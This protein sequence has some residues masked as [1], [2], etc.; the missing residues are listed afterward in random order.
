MFVGED[1]FK[2]D[3]LGALGERLL[4]KS[5]VTHSYPHCWR[6]K[7]KVLSRAT[8]QCFVNLLP[9]EDVALA[10]MDD[11]SWLPTWG[12]PRLA[13]AMSGRADWC[14]SRQRVWGVPVPVFYDGG[15]AVLSAEY[16]EL[17]ASVFESHGADSWFELADQD[18]NALCG[19]P[20]HLTR[21]MDTLDVWLDSGVSWLAV[22]GGAQA[23][24]YL[25][26]SDQHR[27]WFQSSLWVASALGLP[28]PYKTCV[29]H[30]WVVKDDKKFSKS[31]G[32][33]ARPDELVAE[34]GADLVR[35]WVA[36]RDFTDDMDFNPKE[37]PQLQACYQKLRGTLRVLLG[38]LG[39]YKKETA[40]DFSG[41]RQLDLWMLNRLNAVNAAVQKDY[42]DYRFAK[43][44]KRVHDFCVEVSS[45]Y[46]DRTK[47]TLYCDME[48]NPR[49]QDAQTV[50]YWL[51]QGL[52]G[53]LLQW[54]PS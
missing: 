16:A 5:L 54:R 11:V 24:V 17:V 52:F 26:A 40:L 3:L 7:G 42:L 29:T 12:R 21:K 23:D 37:F 36:T 30:G 45:V 31:E 19:V 4:A 53:C 25:E 13:A 48:A 51:F 1:V 38:N 50:F 49:R 27:G 35:L 41:M 10:A 14:V 8:D 28:A 44:F 20:M 18:F 33:G 46:V 22:L 9:L 15:V 2:A 32:F 34:H 6:T 39:G 47:D 43:G